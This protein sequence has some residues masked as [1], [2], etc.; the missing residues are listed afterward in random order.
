MHTA[1]TRVL[2]PSFVR[3]NRALLPEGMLQRGLVV[4]QARHRHSCTQHPD[5]WG[6]L[7]LYVDILLPDEVFLTLQE[8]LEVGRGLRVCAV[9]EATHYGRPPPRR[10]CRSRRA[11][12]LPH[13]GG[14]CA[15]VC[16]PKCMFVSTYVRT[17]V[18]ASMHVWE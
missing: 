5:T 10:S 16:V 15:P 3:D 1:H 8:G 17:Y 6:S 12:V 7:D 11:A 14:R 9:V 4:A 2:S 18:Y 13:G